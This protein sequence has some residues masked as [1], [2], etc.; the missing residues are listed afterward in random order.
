[1]GVIM[2]DNEASR[3]KR[4]DNWVYDGSPLCPNCLKRHNQVYNHSIELQPQIY[5]ESK[6]NNT[7]WIKFIFILT[8]LVFLV[9]IFVFSNF[10]KKEINIVSFPKNAQV[11]QFDEILFNTQTNSPLKVET[12]EDYGYYVRIVNVETNHSVISFFLHPN[13]HYEL[14]IPIGNYR[15]YYGL[16]KEWIN[17]DSLFGEEGLYFK[18][19]YIYVFTEK[20]GY[21][22]KIKKNGVIEYDELKINILD[23]E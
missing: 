22:I 20:M 13:S 4:C 6:T 21:E 7:T 8:I 2:G 9:L 12:D 23:Y 10:N 1:M 11:F 17:H 15:L 16:G 5:D 19:K 3:C 18:S 14:S